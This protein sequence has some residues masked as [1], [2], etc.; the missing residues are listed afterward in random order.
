RS[1]S[2]SADALQD[3][4][5]RGRTKLRGRRRRLSA[6]VPGG[7]RRMAGRRGISRRDGDQRDAAGAQRR[8]HGDHHGRQSARAGRRGGGGLIEDTAGGNRRDGAGD[9]VSIES[10]Q[11]RRQAF[12]AGHRS[13]R[14]WFAVGGDVADRAA[15]ISPASGYRDHPGDVSRGQLRQIAADR[16]AAGSRADIGLALS[17]PGLKTA[18]AGGA[19]AI[20]SRPAPS[21]VSSLTVEIETRM[22]RLIHLFLVFALL[23]VLAVGGGTAV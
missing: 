23:S 14:G 20:S 16:G 15:P 3:L 22:T 10:H 9:T 19:S 6:R 21:L 2:E 12:P 5:P 1:S 4:P 8:Q 18:R 11:S 17:T 7:G 13:R